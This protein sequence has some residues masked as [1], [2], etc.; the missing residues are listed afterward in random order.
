MLSWVLC[1]LSVGGLLV[2]A[3]LG[4]FLRSSSCSRVTFS[5]ETG[6]VAVDS[7]VYVFG[8]VEVPSITWCI[9]SSASDV[10]GHWTGN[11]HSA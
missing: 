3:W 10:A 5:I 8:E 1:R 4:L 7:L 2:K 6:V 11:S 9:G